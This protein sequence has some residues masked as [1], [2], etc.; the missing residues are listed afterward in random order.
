MWNM[1]NRSKRKSQDSWE[2]AAPAWNKEEQHAKMEHIRQQIESGQFDEH[3]PRHFSWLNTLLGLL[4]IIIAF[5]LGIGGIF[6]V[7]KQQSGGEWPTIT[8]VITATHIDTS[9]NSNKKQTEYE[10]IG[11][12]T[13]SVKGNTYHYSQSEYT[14]WVKELV[15]QNRASYIGRT[16]KLWYNPDSPDQNTSFPAVATFSV[17]AVV[18]AAVAL[19]FGIYLFLGGTPPKLWR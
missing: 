14:S 17:V 9:W 7:R 15:E 13:Y 5:A 11:E 4:L 16:I 1:S 18:G 8:A 12:Y 6:A 19:I 2:P 10:L 3:K